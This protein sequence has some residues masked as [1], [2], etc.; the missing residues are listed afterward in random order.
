MAFRPPAKPAQELLSKVSCTLFYGSSRAA[1]ADT[2][3]ASE[4]LLL[5]AKAQGSEAA[6]TASS[7]GPGQ[8]RLSHAVFV[9]MGSRASSTSSAPVDNT[10]QESLSGRG[11]KKKVRF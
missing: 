1:S 9:G 6:A 8:P 11:G 3:A 7:P 4:E 5:G 2:A 10:W